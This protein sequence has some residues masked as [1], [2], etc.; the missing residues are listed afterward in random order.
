[1]GS[2]LSYSGLSAKI[3]AMQV[4][5]T[6]EEQF[7][8]IAQMTSVPQVVAYL[9][10][11]PEYQKR[12]VTVDE[13]SLHRGDVERLLHKSIFENYTKIYH[14]ANPKQRTFLSLY[15]KRY[16]LTLLKECMRYI[17]D[18]RDVTIDISAY[19]KFYQRHSKLDIE[20]MAAC[21]TIEELME[22]IKGSEYYMP[23]SSVSNQENSL[24]FDYAMA[25]DLYYFN[26]IWRTKDKIFTGND[27]AEI[28][29]AYGGK[30]D[31]LNLQWI[32]RSK[33]Y[34]Q[35]APADIYSL[36]IPANYKLKKQ[37][38]TALV[39]APTMEDFNQILAKT[40]YGIHY[41]TL[42]TSTLEEFYT[43]LLRHTLERESS[44]D[45]YSVAIMYSYL[46]QKAHEVNRLTTAI[47]CVRYGVD[48]EETMNHIRTA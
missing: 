9:K 38:I 26:L 25:L 12:W 35:M 8:E 43:Y 33:Q 47:E 3:R 44:K 46:Y 42:N 31:L 6:S 17:F 40:Y 34:Y 13:S 30:F 41:P 5:L 11:T 23:M 37:D 22:S 16:E 15:F 18:H 32:H 10:K 36:L 19:K 29:K 45:P 7:Q 28:T 21:T 14:F 20:R 2:V 48:P 39:E 27:L 24:L 4:K 1:M